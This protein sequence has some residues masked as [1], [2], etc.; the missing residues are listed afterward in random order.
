MEEVS[1]R[2]VAHQ[3]NVTKI[4][5]VSVPDQPGVAAKVFSFIGK[6]DININ[7][8]VQAEH[9]GGKNDISF[10]VQ[11]DLF[12][13]VNPL[14][15]ELVALVGGER[16]VVDDK[17]ATLSLVG[18]GVQREPRVAARMFTALAAEG[19]NIDLIST[20]NLMLTCVI[21]KDR[22]EDG[23]RVLHKEFFEEKSS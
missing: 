2:G 10:L 14:L 16:V 9:H 17:A 8:I 13:R 15:D 21:P 4:S 7:L 5:L 19:I 3:K 18:E 1:V 12:R 23:V 20:S 22:V 6:H 11:T